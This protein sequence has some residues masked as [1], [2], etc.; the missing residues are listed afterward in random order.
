MLL[1]DSVEIHIVIKGKRFPYCWQVD[2]FIVIFVFNFNQAF[3]RQS[4]FADSKIE[5]TVRQRFIIDFRYF[6]TMGKRNFFVCLLTVG[7]EDFLRI[8]DQIK[9]FAIKNS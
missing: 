8:K 5:K 4:D 7:N 6:G 9:L 1:M 2:D 3:F